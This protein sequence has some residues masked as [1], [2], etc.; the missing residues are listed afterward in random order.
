MEIEPFAKSLR[1]FSTIALNSSLS[2]G[3][4][5][6]TVSTSAVAGLSR[7]RFMELAGPLVELP[8]PTVLLIY[9]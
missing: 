7:Q 8:C 1:P 9:C 3:E 5:L 2:A 4:P 6:M